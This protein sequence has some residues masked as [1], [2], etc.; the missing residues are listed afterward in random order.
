[1]KIINNC[2]NKGIVL[3]SVILLSLTLGGCKS[4]HKG[5][6]Q[7][8]PMKLEV[9][10]AAQ[11]MES[12]TMDFSCQTSSLYDIA[13]QPRVS[14][15]L[16]SVNYSQGMPVRK[17]QLLLTIEPNQFEA[18]VA[19]AEAS[20]YSAKASLVQA[21][22]NYKRSV[23][24]A[25]I[26]AIS[27]SSLDEAIANLEVAK[28]N[29]AS[30]KAAVRNA[31]LNL[32]YTKIYSPVDGVIG[33][34]NGNVGEFV[35]AGTKYST[36]NTISNIDSIYVQLS[37]PTSKYLTIIKEDSISNSAINNQNPK[38]L[39]NIRMTLANGD[40]YEPQG[41]YSYVNRAINNQTGSVVFNVLFPN[42]NYTLRPGEYVTV[43][44]DIGNEKPVILIPQRSVMQTQGVNGI[45]V[46]MP[47]STVVYRKVTLG[48]TYGTNWAIESGLNPSELVLT[49]GLGKIRSGMKIIPVR[50]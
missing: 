31:K 46:V 47:D 40:M 10:E 24:L 9:V 27:Q 4:K 22:S 12:T 20:M 3:G 8:P 14:G 11:T 32:S 44:A 36:M 34:T 42:P 18:A 2:S 15:Y 26:N 13:I 30:A 41:V 29:L 25:K 49:E 6:Q 38:L 33:T 5:S 45:Y 19:E 23:P 48:D 1:M 35:G 39:R 7:M 17:G 37:I 28:A 21:E 16:S 43:K 50:K